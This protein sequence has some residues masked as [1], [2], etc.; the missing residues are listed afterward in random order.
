MVADVT[1]RL[2]VV[3]SALVGL[4]ACQA[5]PT[6][7]ATVALDKEQDLDGRVL[8]PSTQSINRYH[9]RLRELDQVHVKLGRGDR[10]DLQ[11]QDAS[12]ERQIRVD[13]LD[14]HFL[15][16]LLPYTRDKVL[17]PF[18]RANLFLGEYARNGVQ[19]SYQAANTRF[20]SFHDANTVFD[21]G[22][23]YFYRDGALQPNPAVTPNRFHVT[24]NC[25]KPGLWELA[26]NDSVG[27]LYHSG[28]EMPSDVYLEMIRRANDLDATDEVLTQTLEYR[29]TFDQV[30]LD[31]G[32]LRTAGA[33]LVDERPQLALDKDIGGYSNQDSR[34]KVQ[35]GYFQVHREGSPL[36]AQT[37]SDLQPGDAFHVR[38]FV[39]PGIYSAKEPKV[40]PFEPAWDRAV[41]RE[42]E[43]HTRIPR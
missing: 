30:S 5:S 23:E 26:A 27:E 31:L 29:P 20:A 11:L 9:S 3:A 6:G 4:L 2:T 19:T 1:L 8:N 38:A 25:L 43:P 12:G 17:D 28:F 15:V 24:N 36:Q 40:I 13:G 7:Q 37:L 16:P 18:D 35:R 33:V 32:R 41:I 34:R 10:L 14:I 42:V 39:E 22:E 21:G